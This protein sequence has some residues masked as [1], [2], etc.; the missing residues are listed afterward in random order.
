M[1]KA[2]KFRCFTLF[3]IERILE[4]QRSAS[5][6][7]QNLKALKNQRIF[8]CSSKNPS[9]FW[10][11]T[12]FGIERIFENQHSASNQRQNL[13]CWKNIRIFWCSS[14]SVKILTFYVIRHGKNFGKSTFGV[15]STSKFEVLKKRKNILT[16]IKKRQNFYILRYSASKFF[17]KITF[18][19]ELTS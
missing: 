18:G 1:E 19:V 9:K 14:K 5:N 3:G 6:W 2:S 17:G 13:K 7:L 15:E 12:L 16:L 10:C 8:Q 4:N 11:F